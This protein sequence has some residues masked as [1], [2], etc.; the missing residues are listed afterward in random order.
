MFGPVRRDRRVRAPGAIGIL[1][2]AVA[3]LDRLV[4]AGEIDADAAPGGLGGERAGGG[5]R[6]S[7][8]EEHRTAHAKAFRW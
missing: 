3:R 8:E 4:D 7:G 2:E 5:E 1:I 6:E